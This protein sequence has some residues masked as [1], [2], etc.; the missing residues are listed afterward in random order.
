MIP[1]TDHIR[2]KHPSPPLSRTSVIQST[3]PHSPPPRPISRAPYAPHPII[4]GHIYP[5]V[6]PPQGHHLSQ[7]PKHLAVS[8]SDI[9]SFVWITTTRYRCYLYLSM[10]LRTKTIYYHD[11]QVLSLDSIEVYLSFK[12]GNKVVTEVFMHQALRKTIRRD[13]LKMPP[14]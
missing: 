1:L 8:L 12:K 13:A 5:K 4:Q 6:P 14:Q 2:I 9:F 3:P 10:I 11:N 7:S